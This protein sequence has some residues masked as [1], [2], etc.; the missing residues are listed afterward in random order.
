M[1]REIVTSRK[2][3]EADAAA[4]EEPAAVD[5]AKNAPTTT[6]HKQPRGGK[7]VKSKNQKGKYE[8]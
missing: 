6:T 4:R 1:L 7:R 5:K 2:A 3:K 8:R